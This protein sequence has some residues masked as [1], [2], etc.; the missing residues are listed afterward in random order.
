[1]SQQPPPPPDDELQFDRV[2]PASAGYGVA[3]APPTCV[4]CGQPIVNQYFTAG[5]KVVC[6]SCRDAVVNHQVGGSK[7]FRLL[8]ATV[9][10]LAAGLLG[11]V[12]WYLV[13]HFLHLQAGLIAILVGFMVGAAVR[14][15]SNQRGG[16]GYQLLAVVL[17]Y[18]SICANYMPDILQLVLKD[19]IADE[20]QVERSTP[21]GR[22]AAAAASTRHSSTVI[23]PNEPA[24]GAGRLALALVIVVAVI[25]AL[26]LAAPFVQGASGILGLLIIGF[27]LWEAWKLN[28]RTQFD[29]AGPY[30]LG[31]PAIPQ[32]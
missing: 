8:K 4:G 23:D 28:R 11:A 6:P 16:L 1:M 27:A 15:G 7:M 25:F 14:K 18:S 17:T 19:D 3:P 29:I 30:S 31:P 22:Q 10:G 20:A 9:F 13:R 2:E 24:P 12:I 32:A 21:T 5:D 26:S